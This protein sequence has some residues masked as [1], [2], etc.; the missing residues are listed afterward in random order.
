MTTGTVSL[1]R[2]CNAPPERVYRA[3]LNPD[4]TAKWLPPNGFT[5]SVLAM[6]A[7]VGG[8][9]RMRFTN[10]ANGQVHAFGGEYLK[11]VPTERIVCTDVFDDT[12]LRAKCAP[13]SP[14]RLC[15]WGPSSPWC[16]RAFPP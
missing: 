11:M 6:D 8:R 10:L 14:S 16:S 9:Y 1:R 2:V 15:R 4:A 7:R 13:R 5:G 12:N 3:F